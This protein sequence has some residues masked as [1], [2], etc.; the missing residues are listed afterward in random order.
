M[1]QL[2]IFIG[3]VS[4]VAC[5]FGGSGGTANVA[6]PTDANLAS[7]APPMEFTDANA[8]L[9][10][11]NRLLDENQTE[12][13]IE[14]LRVAVKL[15]PDLAEAHFKLGIAYSLLEMQMEQ[16]GA[17]TELPTNSKDGK[18]KTNAEKAF[19]HAVEA[20]KKWISAN[21]NDDLAQF[22]LG[23]TYDKLLKD[24]DAE[25]AFKQ[26]VKL[27]PDETEYQT[28]LGSILIKLAKYHEAIGP[29]KKA[30]ELDAENSRA[31]ELLEDAQAGRQRVDYK[32][33]KKDANLANANRPSNSNANVKTNSNSNSVPKPPEA[34]TKPTREDPKGK[35]PTTPANKPH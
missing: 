15:N 18:S 11:G 23:R 22:N 3:L 33:D 9:A 26:A 17:I 21:P 16:S 31:I 24:E 34:N 32:S 13:A 1:K 10:E 29:L 6:E 7:E 28:E 14:A 4:L 12:Q 30:V 25:K 19:E 27:K 35:K 2:L 8:A 20:Y 5:S